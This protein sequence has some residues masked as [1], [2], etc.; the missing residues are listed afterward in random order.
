M[1]IEIS[2]QQTALAV[3]P[4]KVHLSMGHPYFHP[5]KKVAVIQSDVQKA[6]STQR[7]FWVNQKQADHAASS[8]KRGASTFLSNSMAVWNESN[9]CQIISIL[10]HALADGIQLIRL[11]PDFPVWM[12]FLCSHMQAVHSWHMVGQV[13]WYPCGN[14]RRLTC[15][16]HFKTALEG[17]V[18]WMWYCCNLVP[19][20]A[21]TNRSQV[22]HLQR[23]SAS[24]AEHER[25]RCHS[26]Q[27]NYTDMSLLRYMF[28]RSESLAQI[29]TCRALAVDIPW[30]VHFLALSFCSWTVATI[31]SS[32]KYELRSSLV[33]ARLLQWIWISRIQKA[34][35]H[36]T[37]C[38]DMADQLLFCACYHGWK[39]LQAAWHGQG[40]VGGMLQIDWVH[41]LFWFMDE[42]SQMYLY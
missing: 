14:A 16:K 5:A 42:Q 35:V 23:Q 7:I 6:K 25:L 36:S 2:R 27:K 3:G 11:L 22:G 20:A 10:F 32:T 24:E 30:G 37:R 39:C 38:F 40:E 34:Q 13:P 15:S 33:A 31:R 19:D 8:S 4:C 18:R 12:S 9:G 29:W 28:K 17:K 26:L 41:G 1:D 21:A